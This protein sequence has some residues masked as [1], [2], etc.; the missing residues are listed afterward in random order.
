MGRIEQPNAPTRAA[1]QSFL[2][3]S[4]PVG[5]VEVSVGLGHGWTRASESWVSHLRLGIEF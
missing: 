4:M 3:I 2:T 1:H 5:R